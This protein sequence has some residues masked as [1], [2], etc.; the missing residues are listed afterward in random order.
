MAETLNLNQA[1]AEELE[2]L[3]GV[4]TKLAVRIVAYRAEH[5]PFQKLEDLL[6]IPGVGR[7]TLEEIRTLTVIRPARH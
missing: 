2:A 7:K 6:A 1:T 4:G 3:P 5:G